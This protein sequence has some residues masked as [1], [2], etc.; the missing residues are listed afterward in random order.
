M[1]TV[2][3][4]RNTVIVIITALGMLTSAASAASAHDQLIGSAPAAD[5][6]L[7]SSPEAIVLEFNNTILDTGT[8]GTVIQVTNVNGEAVTNGALTISDRTVTQPLSDA[9]PTGQYRVVWRVVSADGHPIEGAYQFAVGEPIGPFEP[10]ETPTPTPTETPEATPEDT[11][12]PMPATTTSAE[13]ESPLLRVGLIA[14]IGAAVGAGIYA[15]VAV[16]R[17]RTAK[18]TLE[19]TKE[20]STE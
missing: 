20:D 13:Q 16:Q 5:E 11:A 18:D 6:S 3:R 15:L 17:K 1:N 8:A 9:L 10:T 14:L 4:L 19:H 12:E 2:Q 7:A